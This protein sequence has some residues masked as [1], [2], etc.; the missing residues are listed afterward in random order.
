M[1]Y[2]AEKSG[3]V[4]KVTEKLKKTY[5]SV[6]EAAARQAIHVLNS[7]MDE[8]GDEG[9]AWASVYSKMNERGLSKQADV[10]FTTYDDPSYEVDVAGV[11]LEFTPS[12]RG[13][14]V[15]IDMGKHGEGGYV[16][17][18]PQQFANLAAELRQ[19]L[20]FVE[21]LSRTASAR[22]VQG[23]MVRNVAVRYASERR[24]KR[25]GMLEDSV[26][27]ALKGG[28]I[29][30][31]PTV[32]SF[33]LTPEGI[34]AQV[35]AS[36]L[37]PATPAM[38]SAILPS[39]PPAQVAQAIA[40][41]P[42]LLADLSP[43]AAAAVPFADMPAPTFKKVVQTVLKTG[44]SKYSDEVL[45]ALLEGRKW[46][47]S[48]ALD[49]SG[50]VLALLDLF[51]FTP[52]AEN[53]VRGGSKKYIET[54]ATWDMRVVVKGGVLTFAWDGFVDY[55]RAPSGKTFTVNT[56]LE[57]PYVSLSK[58]VYPTEQ[59]VEDAFPAGFSDD[60]EDDGTEW[61]CRPNLLP[62]GAPGVTR[63]NAFTKNAVKGSKP[64]A[65]LDRN[66]LEDLVENLAGAKS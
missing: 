63:V 1:P 22:R 54:D 49:D 39:L 28:G 37:L 23:G 41:S 20:T 16:V 47:A 32:K 29:K 64:L 8:T 38:T 66:V 6:P 25:A 45:R 50:V 15:R 60:P 24:F 55:G 12:M 30:G 5:T 40:A 19:A 42:S 46:G 51:D 56:P 35:E 53:A 10:R 27:S 11:E 2:D 36:V 62:K 59:S 7:V 65:S 43:A 18:D 13:G 17:L 4:K 48:D 44:L 26:L 34:L 21:S 9:K 31:V 52:K 61:S 57:D 14:G 3:D 58:A 33:S